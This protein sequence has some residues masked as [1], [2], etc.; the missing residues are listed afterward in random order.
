[1]GE[2]GGKEEKIRMRREEGKEGVEGGGGG[3]EG[4]RGGEGGRGEGETEKTRMDKPQQ[5]ISPRL[6]HKDSF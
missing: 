3:G 6:Y 1:M 5:C 4:R 2:G